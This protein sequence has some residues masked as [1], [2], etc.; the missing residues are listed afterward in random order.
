MRRVETIVRGLSHT[1]MQ[2][3]FSELKV[4]VPRAESLHLNLTEEDEG[5]I[6]RGRSGLEFSE[7]NNVT[8][9]KLQLTTFLLSSILV[10]GLQSIY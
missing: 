8:M 1:N 4:N 7:K 3:L 2:I 9:T 10:I 5:P 6:I